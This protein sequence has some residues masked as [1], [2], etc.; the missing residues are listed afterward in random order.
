MKRYTFGIMLLLLVVGCSNRVADRQDADYILS[1]M[2]SDK[3]LIQELDSLATQALGSKA[4]C[5]DPIW[6]LFSCDGK[7][8]FHNPDWGGVLEIPEEF[9]P[10]DDRWQAVVSFH[11]TTAISLDT[12]VIMSFYAGFNLDD[13]KEEYLD[14]IINSMWEMSFDV[15]DV[16]TGTVLFSDEFTTTSYTVRATDGDIKYYGRYIPMGPDGVMF[17]ASVKYQNDDEIKEIIPMINLY[18][19]SKEGSFLRGSAF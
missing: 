14:D 16:D 6:H 12:T 5:I 9:I 13:T 10:Q 7:R 8:W 17:V 18:P 11:G 2:R 19:L 4:T 1:L 3:E 15:T